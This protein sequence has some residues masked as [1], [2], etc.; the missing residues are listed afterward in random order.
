MPRNFESLQ[1]RTHLITMT[2]PFTHKPSNTRELSPVLCLPNL[3]DSLM[4]LINEGVVYVHWFQSQFFSQLNST[5]LLG[6]SY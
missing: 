2:I 3:I 1:S 4:Y 5:H 6:T